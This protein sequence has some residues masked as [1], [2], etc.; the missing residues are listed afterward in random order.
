MLVNPS[1]KNQN[2]SVTVS[3]CISPHIL[4]LLLKLRQDPVHIFL[5]EPVIAQIIKNISIGIID[6]NI[7]C[8]G[9]IDDFIADHVLNLKHRLILLHI[10]HVF[11]QKTFFDLFTNTDGTT[12]ILVFLNFAYHI[13]IDH[14]QGLGNRC[15]KLLLKC[16]GKYMKRIAADSYQWYNRN[17]QKGNYKSCFDA[18][19]TKS[20]KMIFFFHGGSSC[21]WP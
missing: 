5:I 12:Q 20:L 4:V 1:S 13:Q 15:R 3:M 7:F 2:I 10:C 6:S 18:E 8:L 19:F 17:H 14:G 16:R 11:F 9:R 21:Y